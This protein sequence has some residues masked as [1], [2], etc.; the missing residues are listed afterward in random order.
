MSIDSLRDGFVNLCFDPS[1]NVLQGACRVLFEGQF[2]QDTGLGCTPAEPDKLIKVTTPRDINCLFGLGSV[3]AES[4]HRAFTCCGDNTGIEI[5]AIPRADAAGSVKAEYTM[6]F[7]GTATTDGRIDI[8]WIDGAYNVSVY[9]TA[10]M[11]REEIAVAVHDAYDALETGSGTS[12]PM[13]HSDS[14]NVVTFVAKNGGTVGNCFGPALFNWHARNDYLPEGVTFEFAQTVVGSGN[15]VPLDYSAILGECCYCCI[16]MLYDDPL[17]QNGMIAYVKDAWA[18]DNPQCFGHSYTYNSGTLGQILATDTNS[19]EVSRMAQ[20]CTDPNPGWLKVAAYTAVSC[21]RTVNNP[22]LSIQGPQNGL[23]NCVIQPESCSQCFTFD[24]QEQLRLNGYVVTVPVAGGSGHP[25]Y[26]YVTNDITNNRYDEE[27]R[28]NLTW[29]DTNSRRLAAEVADE[30]A[31][32][33]QVYNGIGL[34]TKNTTIKRGIKGT[35]PRLILGSV[36]TWAKDNVGIL[37]SEFEDIDNDITLQTDFEV[38]PPCRGMPGK[39]HLNMIYRPPVRIDDFTVN[40]K[41]RLL[42]NCNING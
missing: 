36:R 27:G 35:N 12:L 17:W 9:V 38:A 33:L 34:F 26:P 37:F 8:F 14:G 41:P 6:T 31:K 1:L 13:G 30:L 23:L 5:Y 29:R 11:T 25:T 4:L 39:L 32:Q 18:C 16:G 19:P 15:P 28:P 2:Y 10:G 7:G 3:L 40:L 24:E 22:E 21:C 20:C 42:D